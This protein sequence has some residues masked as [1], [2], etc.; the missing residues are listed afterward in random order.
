MRVVGTMNSKDNLCKY[1]Q[2]EIPTC[3]KANHLVFGDGVGNDNIIECSEFK[4]KAL[5]CAGYYPIIGKP[6]DG[7][8]KSAEGEKQ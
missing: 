2:L 7:V 4:I 6:E 3:P 1:C 5:T 8:I